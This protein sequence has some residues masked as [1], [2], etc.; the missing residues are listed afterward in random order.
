[1][2]RLFS[3]LLALLL[4]GSVSR[5]EGDWLY[6]INVGKGDAILIKAEDRLYLIDT[7]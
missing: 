5:A 3:L 4:A 7:G 6:M 1:M 2:K